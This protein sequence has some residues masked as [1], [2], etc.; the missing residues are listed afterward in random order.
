MD[1]EGNDEFSRAIVEG[2]LDQ[3]KE[4]F[5]KMD[6]SLFVAPHL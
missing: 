6:Q 5:D 2:F 1:D 4:T 3:A